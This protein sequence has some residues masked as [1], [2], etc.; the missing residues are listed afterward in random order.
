LILVR[1]Q[2]QASETM[3]K[4]EPPNHALLVPREARAYPVPRHTS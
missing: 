3:T 2:N 4:T 1:R